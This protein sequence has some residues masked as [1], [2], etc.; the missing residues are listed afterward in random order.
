MRS[1]FIGVVFFAAA[2]LASAQQTFSCDGATVE[3]SV[4]ARGVRQLAAEDGLSSIDVS[5]DGRSRVLSYTDGVDFVGAH[6]VK[7]AMGK[8]VVLFHAICNGSACQDLDNWGIVDPQSLQVLLEPRDGNR[9]D[10]RRILGVLPTA[11]STML[12]VE[13]EVLKARNGAQDGSR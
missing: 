4:S 5:R 8:S 10:A 13:R 9:G 6:C 3:V 7:T 2:T 11:P 1:V 12:V